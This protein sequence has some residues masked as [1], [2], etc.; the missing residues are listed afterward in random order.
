GG[1]ARRSLLAALLGCLSLLVVAPTALA[2]SG[3][4]S[5]TVTETGS[6]TSLA[7]IQ[8]TVYSETGDPIHSG[9]TEAVSGNYTI[10]GLAAGS[11]RVEFSDPL[12]KY[13]PQ[14]YEDVRGFYYA[15][16]VLVRRRQGHPRYRC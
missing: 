7:G 5:G 3:S 14:Y 6:K 9:T 4:I 2:A 13:V 1:D 16:P 10:G 15:K 8:V 12:D 11:Y